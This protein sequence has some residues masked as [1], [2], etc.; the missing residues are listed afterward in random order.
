MEILTLPSAYFSGLMH[1]LNI[2]F[3]YLP[4]VLLTVLICI[5]FFFKSKDLKK[6]IIWIII[7]IVLLFF[8][9]WVGVYGGV[10]IMWEA[11]SDLDM[12]PE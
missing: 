12:F 7:F 10:E 3:L 2:D 6:K 1:Y 11:I 9:F 5:Y 8:W 4:F